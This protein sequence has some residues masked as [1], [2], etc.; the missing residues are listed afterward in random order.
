MPNCK[1][2][3]IKGYICWRIVSYWQLADMILEAY[4]HIVW[5]PF[6]DNV[7]DTLKTIIGVHIRSLMLVT[8]VVKNQHN[9]SF[10]KIQDKFRYYQMLNQFMILVE[11]HAYLW[12]QMVL[13]LPLYCYTRIRS[14]TNQLVH[15][16]CK[17]YHKFRW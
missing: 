1:Y 10:K 11:V 12:V 6:T 3:C 15:A 4:K 7:H 5:R 13:T 2:I 17:M 9:L 14:T 16:T 8:H